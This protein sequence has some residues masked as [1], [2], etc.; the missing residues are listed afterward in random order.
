MRWMC[1]QRP[2]H[3]FTGREH[4][5][6]W[7]EKT[8]LPA[9]RCNAYAPMLTPDVLCSASLLNLNGQPAFENNYGLALNLQLALFQ[10]HIHETG[11]L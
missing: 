9:L 5:Q 1:R 4:R 2:N 7:N 3:E 10:F 8:A 6:L 11:S